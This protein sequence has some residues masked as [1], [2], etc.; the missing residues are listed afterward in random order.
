MGSTV[1]C[2]QA[3]SAGVE[4]DRVTSGQHC[5]SSGRDAKAASTLLRTGSRRLSGKLVDQS[6]EMAVAAECAPSSCL[7]QVWGGAAIEP[8]PAQDL[9]TQASSEA[10]ASSKQALQAFAR[11]AARAP[12]QRTS[13]CEDQK[14]SASAC[15]SPHCPQQ[16]ANTAAEAPR[17][18][19]P[20]PSCSPHTFAAC[21]SGEEHLQKQRACSCA[22][23][24]MSASAQE[25][26]A[27]FGQLGRFGLAQQQEQGGRCVRR[28]S[29]SGHQPQAQQHSASPFGGQQHSASPFGAVQ[30]PM[31][32][33]FAAASARIHAEPFS[34]YSSSNLCS[35]FSCQPE[36]WAGTA[37]RPQQS[38]GVDAQPSPFE[39]AGNRRSPSFVPQR[40][41]SAMGGAVAPNAFAAVAQISP[42]GALPSPFDPGAVPGAASAPV[43]GLAAPSQQCRS[44]FEST[45]PNV[46]C[47][48]PTALNVDGIDL[49]KEL[50]IEP[51]LQL[52]GTVLQADVVMLSVVSGNQVLIMRGAKLESQAETEASPLTRI[53]QKLSAGD[54]CANTVISNTE[55]DPRMPTNC[56]QELGIG[57]LCV[58]P[59]CNA[60]ARRVGTLCLGTREPRD[61]GQGPIGILT[62]LSELVVH[63]IEAA[64]ERAMQRQQSE[65]LLAAMDLYQDAFML[66]DT[67]VA[68]WRILHL[69]LM[70]ANQIGLPREEAKDAIFWDVF[71]VRNPAT[72]ERAEPWVPCEAA[73]AKGQKFVLHKVRRC[74]DPADEPCQFTMRFRPACQEIQPNMF[75]CGL[76]IPQPKRPFYFVDVSL[77]PRAPAAAPAAAASPAS[78]TSAS[79]S[80]SAPLPPRSGMYSRMPPP[81]QC[82]VGQTQPVTPRGVCTPAMHSGQS[83]GSALSESALSPT[84]VP[85]PGLE[86]GYVIGRGAFGSVF[87]GTY[88]GEPVAVKIIVDNDQVRVKDG[89]PVEAHITAGLSHVNVVRTIAHAWRPLSS[90]VSASMSVWDSAGSALGPTNVPD[91][92]T[93]LLLELCDRGTL[94]DAIMAKFFEDGAGCRKMSAIL[95]TCSE[96]ADGM[97]YLHARGIVHGDLTGSNVLLQSNEASPLGVTAKVADFGLSRDMLCAS[98]IETRTCGTITHM[99]PEL[100]SSDV[101]SKAA[102]VYAFGV[103]MWELY[104]GARAWEG[105]NHAQVIHAVAIMHST[106]EFDADAPMGYKHLSKRCM[107]ADPADRPG[108]PEVCRTL[109]TLQV[110]E[111]AP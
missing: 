6:S 45:P 15:R 5:S 9:Y 30:P 38:W 70:A 84:S 37:E 61:F 53:M 39:A 82:E 89:L 49:R 103:L 32:S 50:H 90:H 24:G 88:N 75:S 22:P 66:V 20:Q 107:A 41:S 97:A 67:T 102:D 54:S 81:T 46:A 59:L 94:Q 92:E 57:A 79:A 29:L 71:E 99:P 52:V 96:V 27:V 48:Q 62:N 109:R 98:K 1:S 21:S 3:A 73:A 68:K 47:C 65:K 26:A 100:L 86:L 7:G 4:D 17:C 14:D 108:F 36:P 111:A 18:H 101:M 69:N 35:P 106:L 42:F 51:L 85:F 56:K 87:R 11:M 33:G 78:T 25:A 58:K 13:L 63:E 40:P 95:R 72:G 80:P 16:P 10:F 110:I 93:W 28:A 83:H 77:L 64:A 76:P 91:G 23:G 74:G 12:K 43:T 34:N 31:Q 44:A 55:T 104:S 2:M 19:G 60:V 105:L 8:W